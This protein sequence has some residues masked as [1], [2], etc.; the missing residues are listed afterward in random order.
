M[1]QK[2][3]ESDRNLAAVLH[4]SVFTKLFLPLGNFIFPLIIW[5]Y[6]KNRNF[7]DLHGRQALNFQI[8]IFLYWVFLFCSGIAAVFIIAVNMGMEQQIPFQE[9]IQINDLTSAIP[10]LT[11]LSVIG[12]L[13]LALFIFEV[14]VVVSATMKAG[15]GEHYNY[16]LSI[17]FIKSSN[18]SKNEQNNNTQKETL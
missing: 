4:L 16:P 12:I 3:K 9:H 18:Q 14:V 1:E 15:N 7:I 10:L 13:A 6:G 5:V 8:S 17:S 11:A 2:I